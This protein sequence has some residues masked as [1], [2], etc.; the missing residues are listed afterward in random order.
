MRRTQSA[1]LGIVIVA[2]SG[3]AGCSQ[4]QTVATKLVACGAILSVKSI[5]A[6]RRVKTV[7]RQSVAVFNEVE[8]VRLAFR[9]LTGGLIVWRSAPL[10]GM[11]L[12]GIGLAELLGIALPCRKRKRCLL[13]QSRQQLHAHPLMAIANTRAAA[14]MV[15]EMDISATRRT[16]VGH[17]ASKPVSRACTQVKQM[18]FRLAGFSYMING[19]VQRKV[20]V[21]RQGALILWISLSASTHDVLGPEDHARYRARP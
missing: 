1:A 17:N 16:A 8:L 10:V 7:R 15:G 9:R 4:R 14:L 12:M 21:L 19:A 6:L 5:L 11:D 3:L 18:A 20:H 2:V 13:N